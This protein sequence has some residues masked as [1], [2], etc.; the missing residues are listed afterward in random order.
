MAVMADTRCMEPIQRDNK[1]AIVDHRYFGY[2]LDAVVPPPKE[3]AATA[4]GVGVGSVV[5]Y[6]GQ[7][8][9]VWSKAGPT[10]GTMWLIRDEG[11]MA[12]AARFGDCWL[13][14]GSGGAK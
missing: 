12:I 1:T 2:D 7:K 3:R 6:C 4:K 9:T 8:W 5:G 13:A 10:P 11:R 14:P